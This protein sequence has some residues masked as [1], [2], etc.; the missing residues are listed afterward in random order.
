MNILFKIKTSSL[1]QIRD[2]L[3]RTHPFAAER[4]GFVFCRMGEVKPGALVILA[5]TFM[6]VEDGDYLSDTSV[7]AMMGPAAIRKALQFAY[8]NAVGVFHI[9][10]H[11]HCGIPRPSRTD[12]KETMKFVPDFWHVRPRMPHGAL[13]V[14]SDSISGRCWY[15]GHKAP[16]GISQFTFVGSP[17]VSVR[18]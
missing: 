14:S 3:A 15:P 16:I 1:N 13:I 7:G 17:L 11:A 9:H 18:Q 4:V 6:P 8:N 12:L 5:H 10:T 2:D